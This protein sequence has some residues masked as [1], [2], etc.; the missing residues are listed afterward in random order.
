MIQT[1]DYKFVEHQVQDLQLTQ[2]C[3]MIR[4]RP[5]WLSVLYDKQ[6]ESRFGSRV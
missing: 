1:K 6:L 2:H 5:I 3:P 4:L